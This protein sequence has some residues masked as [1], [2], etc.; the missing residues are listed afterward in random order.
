MQNRQLL[1]ARL[2]TSRFLTN[3]EL[4]MFPLRHVYIRGC[5]QLQMTGEGK[6]GNV[7]FRHKLPYI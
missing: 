1:G 5:K 3:E 7:I 6:V 4:I 2:S